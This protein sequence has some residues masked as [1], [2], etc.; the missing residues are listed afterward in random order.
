MHLTWLDSNSWLIEVGETRILLDPWLKGDL[1][2][3]G[4]G[5][6]FRGTR[7]TPLETPEAIDVILLSQ[8]LEDHAHP[9][10]LKHLDTSIPVVGSPNA[11]SVVEPLGFTSI[12]A[13]AHG[14]TH[15]LHD[16]IEIRAIP[17]SPIGPTLVENAYI[18]KDLQTGRSLYYEP[19]GFHSESIQAYAPVDVVLT[20]MINLELP[21]LGP[22]I[23]GQDSALKVA[24]WLKPQVMLPTAAAGEVQYQGLLLSL[25]K[26]QGAV[27]DIR[28]GLRDRQLSTQI[29]EPKVGERIELPLQ[30][31]TTA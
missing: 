24:E 30:S 9:E 16:R 8:G 10:T 22:I 21:L 26:A 4:A 27:D 17:G 28:A 31:P 12:T 2:F 23:K 1:I 15:R 18:I 7:P 11:A 20:P 6:L 25:L 13:L 14:E 29:I 5:W 3:G 19:H